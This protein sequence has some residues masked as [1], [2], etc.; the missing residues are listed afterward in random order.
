MSTPSTISST[1]LKTA[2]LLAFTTL[3]CSAAVKPALLKPQQQF[4][5][6]SVILTGSWPAG[7]QS[8]DLNG[9][10]YP[11][12]IY[13]DY[14][15]TATSSTTHILLSNGDGTFTPGQTIA[16]AGASIAVADFD[17]DGHP[18]LEWVWSVIGEGRV[19]FAHGNGDG[20]FA[21]TVELGTFAQ[22]GTNLPQL[23]TSPPPPCTTPATST[24]SSK[25]PPTPASSS[26]PPAPA[27]PS[28]ASSESSSHGTGPM[29]TADI[30]GDGHTDLLIQSIGP[31]GK[32]EVDVFFGSSNGLLS[33]PPATTAPPASAA[34]LLQDMDGDGHPDLLIEGDTGTL[35]ILHGFPDGTFATTSEGG[36]GSLN[37]ATGAGGHLIGV[38]GPASSQRIYTATPAGVSLLQSQSNLNITLQGLFNAGPSPATGTAATS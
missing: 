1:T 23:A 19:Y 10:G 21:P 31:T 9:D 38:T 2:A 26:S 25:T 6:P 16:T 5:Q 35:D 12:L 18:D 3:H 4:Q 7:I 14:G 32:G 33:G 28:S 30:N 37:P 34:S 24:S 17:R 27:T 13:T 8:A 22:I 15:A 29:A 36:T 20:T 11:D